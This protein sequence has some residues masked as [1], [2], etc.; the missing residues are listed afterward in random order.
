[1]GYVNHKVNRI[2][3]I[4]HCM[5]GNCVLSVYDAPREGDAFRYWYRYDPY[6]TVLT[7]NKES[8]CLDRRGAG[9]YGVGRCDRYISH[10]VRKN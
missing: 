9:G 4:R 6:G 5:S 3:V 8:L 10:S 1:M 7:R 2:N